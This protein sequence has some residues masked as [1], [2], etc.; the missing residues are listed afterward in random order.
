[1][2]KY[3][4][5]L[6]LL[7]LMLS[8]TSTYAANLPEHTGIV[9]DPIG[10]FSDSEIQR[11]EENLINKDY[12]V[13]VLT[14]TG[15]EEAEGER[16]AQEAYDNW[17]LSAN[18]LMLVVTIDPNYVHLVFDNVELKNKVA[19]SSARDAK[20]II[21]QSFV[22]L[23]IEGRVADGVIAVSELVNSI[24]PVVPQS[25]SNASSG[26]PVPIPP[27]QQPNAQTSTVRAVP[28]V[29]PAPTS[30]ASIYII[31]GTIFIFFGGVMVVS[32]FVKRGRIRRSLAETKEVLNE[33]VTMISKAMVSD[34]LKELE[35]GFVQ[36][37]TKRKL[38]EIEQAVLKLH[39]QS[40]V[41]HPKL[42]QIKVTLFSLSKAQQE[43]STLQLEIKS[44]NQQSKSYVAEIEQLER[45][46]IEVRRSVEHAKER[47]E[48]I[49][50]LVEAYARETDTPLG[51]IR[52]NLQLAI[53]SLTA[54]DQLDEFDILQAETEVLLAHQRF[55]QLQASLEEL[56]ELAK[57]NKELPS[58]IQQKEEQIRTIV[59]R[60]QLL[61]I[62]ADPFAILANAKSML[63]QLEDMLQQGNS[64]DLSTSL[65]EADTL[66]EKA[67]SVVK[68]MIEHRDQC[69]RT[70]REIE[71]LM[72]I[73]DQFRE[74][75]DQEF[76]K[77]RTSYAQ[78]HLQE[79]QNR[80]VQIRQDQDHLNG[81]LVEIRAESEA[82][83]QRY[84][85]AYQKSEEAQKLITHIKN[86][87]EQCLSY[88]QSL[89]AKLKMSKEH[90][91]DWSSRFYKSVSILDQ[92]R[93]QQNH[94]ASHIPLIEER[95]KG[96]QI[97]FDEPPYD[98][99]QIEEGLNE[100]IPLIEQF[101]VKVAQLV[102]EKEEA[103]RSLRELQDAFMRSRNRYG[104]RVSMSRY[105]GSYQH[106]Y[107]QMEHLIA[108]GLFTE[109]M[110]QVTEGRSIITQ[111][112][113][114]YKRALEEERRRNSNG[115]GFGGGFGGGSSGSSSWGG[116]GHSSG[117]SSW[118][119]GGRSSG[120]S[121]W[122]GGSSSGS[123]SGKSSGSSKW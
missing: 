84:Q 96:L 92:L 19:A 22:P 93:M 57:R 114:E 26:T 85:L 63:T 16:L 60:E 67:A 37:T 97:Q 38:V 41:L 72:V 17:Q 40:Q 55:D 104:S 86:L 82:R 123:S 103:E 90:H 35:L 20:G 94:L 117:S 32:Q 51:V 112:E 105:T 11:I 75:Y 10:L 28:S 66:I 111:M 7:F 108:I 6:L 58:R 91:L 39:Q 1:M 49:T 73:L 113:S 30:P 24:N 48:Q 76:V 12:E 107:N 83:V 95:L 69:H 45:T 15:L 120:S 53:E 64:S 3:L 74:Q 59:G 122:G 47:A 13:I 70:I 100:V 89:E 23:A 77:L 88:Y 116:G 102:R 42:D 50:D 43:L 71:S 44:I 4:P 119:G 81:L 36:G 121:G 29:E 9:S 109:A 21:D 65:D 98:L 62:D 118:G 34:L 61:L 115:G 110:K 18:Q 79:Q 52:A 56:K 87:R 80:F 99:Y 27:S 68:Q 31:L 8:I 54:A 5:V 46:V 101:S 106:V 25:T 14:A 33:A 2:K 78:V